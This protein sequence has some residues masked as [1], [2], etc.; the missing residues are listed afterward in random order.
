MVPKVPFEVVALVMT[1][2]GGRMVMERVREAVPAPF[3]AE[4]VSVALPAV[5]GTPLISPLVAFKVSPL[6]RLA[7]PYNLARFVAVMR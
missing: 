2:V 5:V 4:I 6:G 7:A 1:G 3:E